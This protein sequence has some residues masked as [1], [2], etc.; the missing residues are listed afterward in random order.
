MEEGLTILFSFPDG[1]I[2]PGSWLDK[3]SKQPSDAF[4]KFSHAGN[5][6]H[7]DRAVCHHLTH[8]PV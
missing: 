4:K 3:R 5:L 1:R 7:P 8:P 6:T 2:I